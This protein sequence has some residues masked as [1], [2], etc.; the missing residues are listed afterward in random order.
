[1]ILNKKSIASVVAYLMLTISAH[2]TNVSIAKP[3]R[4][5]SGDIAISSIGCTNPDGVADG[6][7]LHD[8]RLYIME[9]QECKDGN[10]TSLTKL[11]SGYVFS[12]EPSEGL[13]NVVFSGKRIHFDDRVDKLTAELPKSAVI[14]TAKSKFVLNITGE[15][16][17]LFPGADITLDYAFNGTF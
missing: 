5:C 11:I 12:E 14:Q 1:M 15:E 13:T 8:V 9:F 17:P 6:E 7:D 10:I 3:G 2:A 16:V 4:Q